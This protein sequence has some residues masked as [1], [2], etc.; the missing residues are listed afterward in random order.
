M[1]ITTKNFDTE[2]EKIEINNNFRDAEQFSARCFRYTYFSPCET[3]VDFGK[4]LGRR[5]IVNI[6]P[7]L[8]FEF[9]LF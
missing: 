2:R 6:S 9:P 4:G 8:H 5:K 1:L 3:D 7:H